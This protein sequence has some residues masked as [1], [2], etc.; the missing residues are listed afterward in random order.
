MR[1]GLC[2][3]LILDSV[4][5][6]KFTS[7]VN[8]LEFNKGVARSVVYDSIKLKYKL[9]LCRREIDVIWGFR[10]LLSETLEQKPRKFQLK[11]TY[12]QLTLKQS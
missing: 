4:F 8:D 12:V 11:K 2:W 7:E 10:P 6:S 9:Y 5:I 1:N 3:T